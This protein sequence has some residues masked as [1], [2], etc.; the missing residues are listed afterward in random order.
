M[1]RKHVLI[2]FAIGLLAMAALAARIG[3]SYRGQTL[4]PGSDID[5]R[6]FSEPSLHGQ[7]NTHHLV[8]VPLFPSGQSTV[9]SDY[10]LPI[11]DTT[12]TTLPT[13]TR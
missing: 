9:Q 2:F 8:D 5:Q 10:K 3:E 13:P 12:A 7:V 4:G 11:V 1:N 6:V